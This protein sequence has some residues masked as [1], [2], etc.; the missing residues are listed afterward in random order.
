MLD[1]S[2]PVDAL[3]ILA[4]FLSLTDVST[5]AVDSSGI[6]LKL[7]GKLETETPENGNAVIQSVYPLLATTEGLLL[8]AENQVLL[9]KRV[10]GTGPEPLLGV[11]VTEMEESPTLRISSHFRE[12]MYVALIRVM[13]ERDEAHARMVAAGVV[14]VHEK[15]ALRKSMSRLSAQLDEFRKRQDGVGVTER[16]RQVEREMQQ[17]SEAELISLCQQLASEI[18]ARTSVGL[19][20]VRLKESRAM[21]RENE[22]T[23]RLALENEL[24]D[25]KEALAR[26]QMKLERS[27]RESKLWQQSYEEI[28]AGEADNLA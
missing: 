1:C 18:S 27:R 7:S 25:T 22:A 20:I 10:A 6:D 8:R 21:E 23:E 9:A 16:L 12:A 2:L 17:D 11:P 3:S 14:H 26:A 4:E 15:A 19:E 5:E 13:E 24:R 28:L